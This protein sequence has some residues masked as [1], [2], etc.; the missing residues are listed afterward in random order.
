MP[1]TESAI[2]PNRQLDEID[3]LQNTPANIAALRW[4]LWQPSF[5]E[6]LRNEAAKILL[7]W[8]PEWLVADLLQLMRD[9]K[10][11]PLWR[12]WCV[13][14]LE[15]HYRERRD[16]E[17]VTGMFAAAN[18]A[19]ASPEVQAAFSLSVLCRDLEWKTTDPEHFKAFKALVSVQLPK[20]VPPDA[21]DAQ[22]KE[23]SGVAEALLDAAGEGGLTELAPAIEQIAGDKR[24]NAGVRVAAVK[25]LM[26]IGRKESL[27]VLQ[28]CAAETDHPLLA[29]FAKMA[30][31]GVGKAAE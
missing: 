29:Q 13:Q 28:K 20:Q 3:K 8:N 30:V 12:G 10:Q 4:L 23:K 25:A 26:L 2:D 19:D 14:Y 21:K 7:Q 1:F 9:E 31:A 11:P 16:G 24:W 22:L 27:P 18:G 5:S 15:Q 17:S 6:T